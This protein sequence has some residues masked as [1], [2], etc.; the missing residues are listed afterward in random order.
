MTRRR[1]LGGLALAL[2]LVLALPALASAHAVLL[3]ATPSANATLAS[4]PPKVVLRFSESVQLL[5]PADMDV[6]DEKGARVDAGDAAKKPGD[7]RTLQIG[8]RPGLPAGTYT[9]RYL[10]VSADSHVIGGYYVFG[11]GPGPLAAPYLSGAGHG[12]PAETSAWAVS[13][14]FLELIGLGGLVGLLAF[15][16][17][18]WRAVW[19]DGPAATPADAERILTWERDGFWTAFG[20]LAIVAVLSEG[21]LLVVKSA[22]ALGVGVLSVLRAPSEV[23][24]I[25][26]TTD[27]GSFVQVRSGLS[28]GLFA[29]GAWRFVA[30]SGRASPTPAR[31]A[32]SVWAGL[33][34]IGLALAS[35]ALLSV[36]GHASQA[37]LAWFQ[38]GADLLHLASV[39]VW[40]A[41]LAATAI[42]VARLPR[43]APEG[44]ALAA[45]VL[46]RFSLVATV[47]VTAAIV[48]GVVRSAGELS[49]PAQLWDTSYGR[50]ILYKLLLLCPVAYLALH[51]RRVVTSLRAVAAPNGATLRMVRRDVALELLLALAIIVV[52]SVL[53]AQVPGR[54]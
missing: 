39:A 47:T 23:Q 29:L 21:Y 30:E 26:G 1:L 20:V 3:G 8:L 19:R 52:A 15:R 2:A 4:A 37:P 28:A 36:Q 44:A 13:A 6:V 22:S 24:T 17:L 42:I 33:A 40:I 5:K 45:R 49:D 7:A 14:R 43:I 46:A 51:N 12:G 54:T 34:M 50:S 48:T 11:V 38:T 41:G 9:V 16:L 10:I 35:I 27:F 31:A 18:V 25:L 53:V 32:G